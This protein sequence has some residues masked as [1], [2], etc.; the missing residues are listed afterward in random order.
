MNTSIHP[1]Y[2][3][4]AKIRCACGNA[5]VVGSTQSEILVELCSA[6]HP[7]F[8]GK[9]KLLDTEGRVERFKKKVEKKAAASAAR[10]G[11]KVKKERA[12]ARKEKKEQ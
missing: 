8:T 5:A 1:A 7:F 3:V 12:T 11:K 10:V 4:N 2:T 9:Q 6:C